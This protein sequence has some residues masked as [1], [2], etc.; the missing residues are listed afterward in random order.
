ML[1]VKS[2][3]TPIKG[4]FAAQFC[5]QLQRAVELRKAKTCVGR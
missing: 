3:N 2:S 4:E 1:G 5:E